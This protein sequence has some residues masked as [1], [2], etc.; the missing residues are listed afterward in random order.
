MPPIRIQKHVVVQLEYKHRAKQ[1]RTRCISGK[2]HLLTI[3]ELRFVGFLSRL[4]FYVIQL[5]CPL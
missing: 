2:Q 4:P 1:Y 5:D 3:V